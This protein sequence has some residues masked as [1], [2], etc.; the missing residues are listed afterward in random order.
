MN[1]KLLTAAIAAVIAA[2]TAAL[3]NDV[4]IYGVIH[5]SVDYRTDDYKL[6]QTFDPSGYFSP[7]TPLSGTVGDNGSIDG[8]DVASRATRIGFKGSEDLANGLKAIWKIEAQADIADGGG[9]CWS[10]GLNV[11]MAPY[12]ANSPTVNQGVV[13]KG[14][15]MGFLPNYSSGTNLA[16]PLNNFAAA[17]RETTI[18]TASFIQKAYNS[19]W[20]GTRLEDE[21]DAFASQQSAYY[22]GSPSACT[23]SDWW[24]ARNA[25]VGL[26]GGWGTFLVGRH[27]T[28]YKMSTGKLDLFADTLADYNIMIGFVDIRTN[29]AIAY[30]SPSWSGLSFAGAMVAPQVYSSNG[31]STADADGL[32]EAYSLALTYDNAGFFASVAYENLSDT[33]VKAWAGVPSAPIDSNSKWRFGLGWTGAGFTIGGLYEMEDNLLGYLSDQNADATRWQIQAGYTF[34]NNMIKAMY[35]QGDFSAGWAY[36]D[37]NVNNIY[38][39]EGEYADVVGRDRTS[40]DWSAWAIGIDH[41][42]SKRTKA[43]ILY[44]NNDYNQDYKSDLAVVS[45]DTGSVVN[46]DSGR[47]YNGKNDGSAGGFSIG[48]VHSF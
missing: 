46:S 45:Q 11:G 2:P 22:G 5:A 48:M 10:P 39:G 43:Y 3:A 8:F 25:Y 16:K 6:R 24:T 14:Q 17:G 38:L 21:I 7:L 36:F 44:T 37:T 34:G 12:G 19:G 35:G 41:N 31:S 29:S 23:T 28:P 20:T 26:A 1:K 40:G 4:T 42:F 47:A 9:G 18:A 33:W 13:G 27:D 32:A 15:G 30:V